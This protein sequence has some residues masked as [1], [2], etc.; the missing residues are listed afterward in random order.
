M[1]LTE[2]QLD[3]IETASKMKRGE[4]IKINACAGS[5]K[6]FILSKIAE[7]NKE[8]KFLYLAFN[9]SIASE[10]SKKQIQNIDVKTIHSLA[11]NFLAKKMKNIDL[12][13]AYTI[14]DIQEFF[15]SANT[16]ELISIL[17]NFEQFLINDKKEIETYHIEKLWNLVLERRLGVSHNFYLKYYFLNK[18]SQEISKKYDF[19]FLDEAQDTNQIMLDIVLNN[20]CS[21]ILV[22]DTHQ[23]IYGFNNTINAMKTL[24]TN[25]SKYLSKSFRSS[26]NVVN[27]AKYFLDKY[28]NNSKIKMSSAL[29][30][31]KLYNPS[32]KKAFIMRTNSGIID[33]IDKIREKE[34][35]EEYLLMKNP[36]TIFNLIFDL[37][38]FR[39]NN[40]SRI[41]KENSFLH[42]F[43]S[44]IQLK[45]YAEE[46]FD[47]EL[48][49]SLIM[50]NK[51]YDFKELSSLSKR[52]YSE[53]GLN[54]NK[55]ITNAHISKGLEWDIVELYK[56]FPNLSEL[57]KKIEKEKN[58]EKKEQMEFSFEQEVNLF[59]VAITRAKTEIIDRTNNR[60]EFQLQ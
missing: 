14:F 56:D 19:V 25:Y 22:G 31:D 54:K 32:P 41:S 42:N 34:N 52:L 18:D 59:Y 24:E 43:S 2:E 30:K 33:F 29:A 49:N 5:G 38:N 28:S 1:N 55:I 51:D 17:R 21:K 8:K 36:K 37:I 57:A 50:I 45:N 16:N 46:T 10:F 58:R 35:I 47:S 15:P 39:S 27:Y 48:Q 40:F 9:K 6:T 12:V 7:A 60:K 26:D 3:I 11:F 20:E 4:I 53:N 13:H 44:M 23:N